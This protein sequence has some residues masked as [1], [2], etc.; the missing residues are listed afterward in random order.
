MIVMNSDVDKGWHQK[1]ITGQQI[2][3]ALELWKR[4]TMLVAQL[5]HEAKGAIQG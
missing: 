2:P 3:N 5:V 1:R 4:A